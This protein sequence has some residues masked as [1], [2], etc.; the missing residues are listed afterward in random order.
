MVVTVIQ[1]SSTLRL[2]EFLLG[3]NSIIL[4]EG[5]RLSLTL[6]CFMFPIQLLSVVPEVSSCHCSQ[7][8]A[9]PLP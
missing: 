8:I 1:I 7:D 6:D 3:T 2:S 5:H 4:P 9:L